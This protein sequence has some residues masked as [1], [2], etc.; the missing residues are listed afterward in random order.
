LI[1][2]YKRMQ[3]GLLSLWLLVYS[4]S[5]FII[6]DGLTGGSE[7]PNYSTSKEC[8]TVLERVCKTEY[9]QECHQTLE[10]TL[11]VTHKDKECWDEPTQECKTEYKQECFVE[12]TQECFTH[13]KCKTLYENKCTTDYITVCEKGG[14]IKEKRIKRSTGGT[15]I[16]KSS[17]SAQKIARRSERAV[18]SALVGLALLRASKVDE[19]EKSDLPIDPAQKRFKRFAVLPATTATLAFSGTFNT[20]AYMQTVRA[21]SLASTFIYMKKKKLGL[22]GLLGLLALKKKDDDQEKCWQVPETHC[23]QV[24]HKKCHGEGERKCWTVPVK[25][26]KNVPREECRTIIEKQCKIVPRQECEQVPKQ[27]CKEVPHE[28]CWEEPR[29]TCP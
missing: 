15:D 22:L 25:E 27:H 26:C 23:I 18:S 8:S 3:L 16:G 11:C 10:N 1:H 14:Y 21:V 9:R 17:R 7:L 29:Q 12:E 5:C 13:P 28:K 24:P 20:A 4:V 19:T 2:F 6:E